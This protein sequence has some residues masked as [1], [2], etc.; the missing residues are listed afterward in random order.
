MVTTYWD[1]GGSDEEWDTTDNW[2]DGV[3]GPTDDAIFDNRTSKNCNV[4]DAQ[5]PPASFTIDGY[6]GEILLEDVFG[7]SSMDFN[8]NSGTLKRMSGSILFYCN[9]FTR[10]GGAFESVR[11]YTYGD[12]LVTG[13]TDDDGCTTRMSGLGA[14]SIDVRVELN[15]VDVRGGSPATLLND[16]VTVSSFNVNYGGGIP[17]TL[18]MNGYQIKGGIG[19]HMGGDSTDYS[20]LT[21]SGSTLWQ[22]SALS[23]A[24]WGSSGLKTTV[25]TS[26]GTPWNCDIDGSHLLIGT[27]G[28]LHSPDEN[29]TFDVL[30][31]MR[32]ANEFYGW[33]VDLYMDWLFIDGGDWN[34]G[35][36]DLIIRGKNPSGYP[37][38][39]YAIYNSG[40]MDVPVGS[41]VVINTTS[42][43]KIYGAT[44]RDLEIDSS[45]NSITVTAISCTFYGFPVIAEGDRLLIEGGSEMEGELKVGP[46]ADGVEDGYV[47][48]NIELEME[49]D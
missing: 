49:G 14:Y 10:T 7:D 46:D 41:K 32:M 48:V 43:C 19:I 34:Q 42:D 6:L 11:Y 24:Q 22:V 31:L 27:Y 45:G 3:P 17:I 12:V 18:D 35:T 8:M 15:R 38:D 40:T 4:P 21:P 36:S 5:T 23:Q 26:G 9:N 2:S 44:L 25:G 13:G 33:G 30:G 37:G 20:I 29:G 47:I 1:G 16:I 28:V 39:D